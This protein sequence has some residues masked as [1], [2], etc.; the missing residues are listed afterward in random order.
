MARGRDRGSRGRVRAWYLMELLEDPVWL[1][2][3]FAA[4]RRFPAEAELPD[5]T[6]VRIQIELER[7]RA[8]AK[9]LTV[10]NDAGIGYTALAGIPVRDIVATALLIATMKAHATSG[11]IQFVHP[12]P[13][14][15][16]LLGELIRR[17]VGYRPRLLEM[18]DAADVG[19]QEEATV[20]RSA[21]R[22]E[23]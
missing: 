21:A 15:G 20:R 14:D 17:L 3:G 6:R 13:D 7:G 2:G 11:G 18:A 16:P 10:R 8:R 9:E 19:V 5:G 23:R 12:S 4:P 1:E 22:G